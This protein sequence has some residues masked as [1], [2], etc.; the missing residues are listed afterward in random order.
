MTPKPAAGLPTEVVNDKGRS[1][2]ESDTADLRGAFYEHKTPEAAPSSR[3]R[4]FDLAE[5]QRQAAVLAPVS[6][7]LQKG[8]LGL[9]M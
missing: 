1:L 5:P 9:L 4:T 7:A 2:Q 8:T 3:L 6:R